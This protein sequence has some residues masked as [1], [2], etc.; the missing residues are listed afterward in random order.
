MTEASENVGSD[1]VPAATEASENVTS[2]EVSAATEASET[3][4]S[5]EVPAA[6]EASE[7]VASDEVPAATESTEAVAAEEVPTVTA[8]AVEATEAVAEV[9][10][11]IETDKV[12]V[13]GSGD[14]MVVSE[15]AAGVLDFP[16]LTPEE[17]GEL[18]AVKG[19]SDAELVDMTSGGD[20]YTYEQLVQVREYL[21][22]LPAEGEEAIPAFVSDPGMIEEEVKVD[23]AELD[24]FLSP[25][26]AVIDAFVPLG[27]EAVAP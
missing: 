17:I 3:V 20:W 11:A 9:A 14:V 10:E 12:I 23:P 6:T 21:E 18:D 4:A 13:D 2:D 1:E 26:A 25:G 24:K 22:T 15:P 7:T 16:H 19:L 5:D 27:A 8:A